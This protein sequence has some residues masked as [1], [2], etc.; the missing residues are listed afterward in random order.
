MIMN[1]DEKDDLDYG[2]EEGF[3]ILSV[4]SNFHEELL[5][6][7]KKIRKNIRFKNTK[8]RKFK[9][10]LLFNEDEAAIDTVMTAVT[11]SAQVHH[12]GS[13]AKTDK[14][15]AY[16]ISGSAIGLNFTA[17]AVKTGWYDPLIKSVLSKLAE[18]DYLNETDSD[19]H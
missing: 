18:M 3:E 16:V 15:E 17:K 5:K 19:L 10:G 2:E 9:K 11:D 12:H 13:I 4:D 6:R 8:K 1:N 14:N 7:I